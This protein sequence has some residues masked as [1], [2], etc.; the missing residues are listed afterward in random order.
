[1]VPSRMSWR[2]HSFRTSVAATWWSRSGHEQFERGESLDDRR[3]RFGGHRTRKEGGAEP[4]VTPLIDTS[5]WSLA[6]RRA[7]VGVD[8]EVGCH[9]SRSTH[10][11]VTGRVYAAE[12]GSCVRATT[13]TPP[14]PARRRQRAPIARRPGC[15][16]ARRS[17]RSSTPQ[18]TCCASGSR[19]NPRPKRSGCSSTTTSSANA[20][21]EHLRRAARGVLRPECVCQGPP[22]R[23][24]AAL[25]RCD[26]GPRCRRRDVVRH[27]QCVPHGHL[28]VVTLRRT[29][30]QRL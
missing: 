30:S 22:A 8:R 20:G 16:P 18:R 2:R 1:M 19:A 23:A 7:Q 3:P 14:R 15:G 9:V 13:P 29:P 11:S 25:P 27:A 26:Q 6:L 17:R 5:V 10:G 28:A 12:L 24:V 21:R 4:R